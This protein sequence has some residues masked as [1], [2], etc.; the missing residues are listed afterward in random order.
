MRIYTS[1]E[2]VR[3]LTAICLAAG[4]LWGQPAALTFDV[5]S[6]KIAGAPERGPMFC[7]VPCAPGERI[8][9]TGS[10]VEVRY[11]SLHQLIVTAYR[12][13]PFQLSGP[14]WMRSQRFDITAKM[15]EGVSKDRLPEML[16]ALLVD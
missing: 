16:Q 13:K 8:S 5:A 14:E 6:I 7:I 15:P 12:I 11:T 3:A 9:V 4:V 10:R 2:R 1:V